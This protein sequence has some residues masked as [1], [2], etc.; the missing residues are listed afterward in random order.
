[1]HTKKKKKA[2]K[3]SA[4]IKSK[5]KKAL[6]PNGVLHS[7]RTFPYHLFPVISRLHRI[8]HIHSYIYTLSI[9]PYI[10]ININGYPNARHYKS[11]RHDQRQ[12]QLSCNNQPG[13]Y[14]C[15]ISRK[16]PYIKSHN[17][18]LPLLTVDGLCALILL[19]LKDRDWDAVSHHAQ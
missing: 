15:N 19:V 11:N 17:P 12:L 4:I 1:M 5:S 10:Y 18:Y 2:T 7:N 8:V 13:S 16:P 3:P 14:T 9:D 6:I